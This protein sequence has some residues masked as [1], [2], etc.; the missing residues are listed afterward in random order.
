M[1]V[2]VGRASASSTILPT[3]SASSRSVAKSGPKTLTS[4]GLSTPAR[5]LIWSCTS[6]TNSV[7]SSGTSALSSLAERVERSRSSAGAAPAGLR[8]TRM[9][10]VNGSVAKRPSSAPVRR[11]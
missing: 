4:I 9:S 5:S 3:C 7:S 10:P 2:D 11:M 1:R 8:L 6:G